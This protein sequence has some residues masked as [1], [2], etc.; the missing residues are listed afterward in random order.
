ML[1]WLLSN[2]EHLK[3]VAHI[4]KFLV[5]LDIPQDI[6][7]DAQM[8]EIYQQYKDLQAEFKAVH[9]STESMRQDAMKPN[10]LKKEIVQ[11]EA[12]REQLRQKISSHKSKTT[13][14][15][16]AEVLEATSKLRK[17][18]EQDAQLAQREA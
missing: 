1:F 7:V 12:E 15:A 13:G 6:Q 16:F 14:P 10:E 17:M 9:E 3:R 5:P 8:G 2:F 18:Q 11:L 4:S